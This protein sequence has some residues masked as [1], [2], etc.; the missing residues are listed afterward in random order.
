MTTFT[1]TL[2]AH[3]LSS[4]RRILNRGWEMPPTGLAER[5][6]LPRSEAV[7][8]V[9]LL[10]LA[11]GQPIALYQSYTP[12]VIAEAVGLP[13]LIESADVTPRSVPELAGERLGLGHISLDQQY[14]AVALTT[15]AAGPMNAPSGAPAFRVSTIFSAPDNVMLGATVVLYRGDRYTFQLIRA[16]ELALDDSD[17]P[18]ADVSA[19]AESR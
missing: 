13:E 3:G 1:S 18:G 17:L 7:F 5:L 9:E 15:A 12:L 19:Q 2:T 4:E 6:R 14:E 11:D 10:G 8:Y 16:V